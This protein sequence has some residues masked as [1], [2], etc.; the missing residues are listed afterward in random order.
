MNPEI[1]LSNSPEEFPAFNKLYSLVDIPCEL[2]PGSPNEYYSNGDYWWPD[3][4]KTDGLPYIRKDGESNPDNFFGHRQ[5]MMK[6]AWLSSE[7]TLKFERTKDRKYARQAWDVLHHWFVKPATKM[8]P[9]LQY[10][11]AIPGRCTG[12]GIGLIDTFYLVETA[13]AILRL[14]KLEALDQE[15]FGALR[16]WFADY[17]HWFSTSEFGLKEKA[18]ANN[19]GTYWH[20][21]AAAFAL[22]T[23]NQ[24]ILEM[25]REDYKTVLLPGQM[26]EDGSFP[27]EIARTR[28]YGY[29][30]FNLEGM[31]ALCRILTTPEDNLFHF[32]TPRGLSLR[33]GIE[34]MYPYLV[35][36]N[37]WPYPKDILYWNSWPNKPSCLLFAGKAYQERKYLDLWNTLPRSPWD[38]KTAHGTLV[39]NHELWF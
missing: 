27:R 22:L 36:K 13:L 25:C 8:Q 29:S 15:Q 21:Q 9:H 2:S 33:D 39:H 35:D 28:P 31:A 16:G 20:V 14:K 5:L 10:A 37:S 12:R 11:Q 38:F 6:M 19:H 23:E 26:A 18:E 34:F 24:P 30:I 1:S 32:R 3:E 4:T 17:L 7:F